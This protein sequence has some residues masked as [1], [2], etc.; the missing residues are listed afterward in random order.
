MSDRDGKK[1]AKSAMARTLERLKSRKRNT[2]SVSPG[3]PAASASTSS[4]P[5][6]PKPSVIMYSFPSEDG[7]TNTVPLIDLSDVNPVQ[8]N[9][10]TSTT[11][12][13]QPIIQVR[14]QQSLSHNQPP[15]QNR[16]HSQGNHS[17]HIDIASQCNISFRNLVFT[18]Y[19]FTNDRCF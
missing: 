16:E 12:T 2:Q 13:S 14:T 17:S 9:S 7:S 8:N 6:A 5:T 11:T 3:A 4:V 19:H 18:N 10:Q 1:D 15:Q